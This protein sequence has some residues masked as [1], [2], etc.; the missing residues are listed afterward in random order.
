MLLPAALVRA[1]SRSADAEEDRRTRGVGNG[2]TATAG[3]DAGAGGGV[4]ADWST[5]VE[6]AQRHAD[7]VPLSVEAQG[8]YAVQIEWSDGHSS[9]IY[10]YELLQRIGRA[11]QMHQPKTG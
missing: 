6:E 9:S 8:L 2:A 7:C 10:S 11:V 3:D 5:L 4:L 1:A